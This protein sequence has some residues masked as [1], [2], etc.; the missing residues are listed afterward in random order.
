M[1]KLIVWEAIDE[2]HVH[3]KPKKGEK[4]DC[5]AVFPVMTPLTAEE[6]SGKLRAILHGDRG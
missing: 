2:V 5:L 1:K 4:P 3:T 6:I